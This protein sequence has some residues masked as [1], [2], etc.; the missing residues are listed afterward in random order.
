MIEVYGIAP[1]NLPLRGYGERFLKMG[2]RELTDENR[3]LTSAAAE[4]A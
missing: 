3:Y 1:G 2:A 4:S